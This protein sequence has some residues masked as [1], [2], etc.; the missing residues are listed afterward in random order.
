VLIAILLGIE[1]AGVLGA[2]AAVPIA[3]S[4]QVLVSELLRARQEPSAV[5]E[6][7]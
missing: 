4:V 2:L 5:I 3:A 7:D 6:P 1:V